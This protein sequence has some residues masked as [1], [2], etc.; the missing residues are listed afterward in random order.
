VHRAHGRNSLACY[1]IYDAKGKLLHAAVCI[2][3]AAEFLGVLPEEIEWAIEEF[4]LCDNEEYVLVGEGD[5]F[6]G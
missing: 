1:D 5:P 4:G 2:Q 6:P 3:T